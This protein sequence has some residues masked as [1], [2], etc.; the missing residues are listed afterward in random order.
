[1]NLSRYCCDAT[2]SFIFRIVLKNVQ[3]QPPSLSFPPSL[4]LSLT[5]S[6]THTHTHT[7]SLT[8]SLS[9]SLSLSLHQ[10]GFGPKTNVRVV[11]VGGGF[12]GLGAATA[13]QEAGA[14]VTLLEVSVVV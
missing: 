10:Q 13:L 6:H 8:L 3:Q 1:M 12:S 14:N 4:S 11:V 2:V 5:R 7:L 9:L